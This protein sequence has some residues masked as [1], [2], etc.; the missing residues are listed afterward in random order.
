MARPRRLQE[1]TGC[2]STISASSGQPSARWQYT[3]DAFGQVSRALTTMPA[4]P[5][6]MRIR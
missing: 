2:R 3:F 1:R 5:S 6:G 4:G